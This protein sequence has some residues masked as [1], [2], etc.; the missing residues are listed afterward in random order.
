[1]Q[2]IKAVFKELDYNPFWVYVIILK[3]LRMNERKIH[4]LINTKII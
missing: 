1:M 4:E 3:N 2:M